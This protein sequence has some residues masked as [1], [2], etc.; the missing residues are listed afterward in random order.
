MREGGEDDENSGQA[1]GDMSR[2]RCGYSTVRDR[3][4][5]KR[6]GWRGSRD[7]TVHGQ[8]FGFYTVCREATTDSTKV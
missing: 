1:R 5:R 4:S 8:E 7:F 3:Q 2:D 6:R